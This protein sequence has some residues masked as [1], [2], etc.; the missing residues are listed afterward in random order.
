[1]HRNTHIIEFMRQSSELNVPNECIVA[2]QTN[3]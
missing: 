2:L 3:I 1:M